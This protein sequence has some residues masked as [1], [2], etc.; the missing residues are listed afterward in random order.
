MNQQHTEEELRKL[1]ETWAN[2]E[3]RGDV[4]RLERILADD[5]TGIGP[6]GFMLSKQEWLARHQAGDLKYESFGL[7]ELGLRV[8]NEDAAILIGR[9]TQQAVYRGNPIDARFRITLVFVRRQEEWQLV[10]LQ[11]SAIGQPPAFA[12][13]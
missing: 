8:Y 10:S 7:D 3:L 2:A 11:L 13:S 4:T 1:S 9:Q 12:R 6:L 5:Y